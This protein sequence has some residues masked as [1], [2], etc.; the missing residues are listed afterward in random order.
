MGAIDRAVVSELV[1]L[2]HG[3][4]VLRKKW[5]QVNIASMSSGF[6]CQVYSRILQLRLEK[7]VNHITLARK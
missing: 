1:T 7:R 6:H 5:L 3:L 2:R 4:A